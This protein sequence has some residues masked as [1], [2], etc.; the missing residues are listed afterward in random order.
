MK[1]GRF[2]GDTFA[3]TPFSEFGGVGADN[4]SVRRPFGFRRVEG[5]GEVGG[6]LGEGVMGHWDGDEGG[7]SMEMGMRGIFVEQHRLISC[8][9]HLNQTFLEIL[10]VRHCK[11]LGGLPVF[12]PTR[13]RR[14]RPSSGHVEAGQSCTHPLSTLAPSVSSNMSSSQAL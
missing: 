10:L 12:L 7:V 1:V 4:G 8:R 13:R 6:G 14:S 9:V 2:L 3:E 11:W 5:L